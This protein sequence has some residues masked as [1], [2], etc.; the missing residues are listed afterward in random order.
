[1]QFIL[2]YNPQKNKQVS[3]KIPRQILIGIN[4]INRTFHLLQNLSRVKTSKGPR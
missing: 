1:M 2:F 3:Q 4:C